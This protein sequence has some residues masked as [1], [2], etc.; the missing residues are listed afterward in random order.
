MKKTGIFCLLSASF[1]MI[2]CGS[3]TTI[4][5]KLGVSEVTLPCTG[6]DYNSD[7]KNFRAN[8]SG[9]SMDQMTA[10]KKAL[11]NVR[12]LLATQISSTMKVVSDNYVKSS[13]FNNAEEV[14]ENFEENARTVV[15][16]ELNNIK[17]VCEKLLYDANTKKYMYYVALEVNSEELLNSFSERLTKDQSLK[18]DYNYEKFKETFEKEMEKR[19]NNS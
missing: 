8:G 5:S 11:S 6:S 7:K 19:A 3:K 16:Q 4:E 10:K 14:L 9:D 13:E 1:L 18:V 15:D 17:T 2:N 12:T